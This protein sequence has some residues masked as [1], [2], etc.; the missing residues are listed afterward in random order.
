VHCYHVKVEEQVSH[1]IKNIFKKLEEAFKKSERP[2]YIHK[3]KVLVGSKAYVAQ[4]SEWR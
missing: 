3:I 4:L 1:V 2:L